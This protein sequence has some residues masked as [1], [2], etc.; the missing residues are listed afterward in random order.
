MN[1]YTNVSF[2]QIQVT[3]STTLYVFQNRQQ[4]QNE[5]QLQLY[6][7]HE[8]KNQNS[9]KPVTNSDKQ[10]VINPQPSAHARPCSCINKSKYCLN[11]KYISNKFLLEGIIT[12]TTENY[13]IRNYYD[14]R[15]TKFKSQYTNNCKSFKKKYQTDAKLFNEM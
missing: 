9:D 14:I 15:E 6:V 4:K 1:F 8:I 11:N 5:Y 13:R 2:F 3:L 10:T 7:K 12:L